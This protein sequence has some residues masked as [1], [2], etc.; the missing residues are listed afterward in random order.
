MTKAQVV[1]CE[2]QSIAKNVWDLR[3]EMRNTNHSTVTSV[4]VALCRLYIGPNKTLCDTLMLYSSHINLSMKINSHKPGS[5]D[6]FDFQLLS[7]FLK[8]LHWCYIFSSH[9]VLSCLW[10]QENRRKWPWWSLPWCLEIMVPT[11]WTRICYI[12]Q[13][14]AHI[15]GMLF[16]YRNRHNS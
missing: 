3:S 16:Y 9:R 7:K 6:K 10:K 8:T 1:L 13:V 11:I 14:C 4:A 5:N 2:K 15:Q 12:C